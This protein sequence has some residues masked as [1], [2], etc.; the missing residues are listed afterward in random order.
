VGVFGWDPE[1]IRYGLNLDMKNPTLWSDALAR[2]LGQIIDQQTSPMSLPNTP[3]LYTRGEVKINVLL[4]A[5][6]HQTTSL[7]KS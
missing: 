5:Q 7:F 6:H 3:Y 1:P 4:H 2:Q